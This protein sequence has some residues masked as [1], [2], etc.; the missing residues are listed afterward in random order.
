M[1]HLTTPRHDRYRDDGMTLIELVLCVAIVGIIVVSLTGVVMGYLKASVSASARMTESHDVQ[2]A[3]AYWQRDVASI[4]VRSPTYDPSDAVH[5]YALL[6]SIGVTPACPLPSGTTVVT[7]AW[8]AYDVATPD[9]PDTVTVTYLA[10]GHGAGTALR[11]D[12]QRV[13]CTGTTVTSTTTVADNLVSVPTISCSTTCTG[14]G[15]AVPIE[16]RMDLVSN[17]PDGHH[18]ATYTATLAGERRQT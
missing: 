8:S 2:F 1:H 9:T 17:D 7:L 16:V 6:Q 15:N 18:A 10:S 13:R 4:G 12:L 11:Y 3:A 5:S 14:A